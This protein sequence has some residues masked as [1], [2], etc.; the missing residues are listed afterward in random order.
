M[1]AAAT[2]EYDQEVPGVVWRVYN[3]E[4]VPLTTDL[5][6]EGLAMQIAALFLRAFVTTEIRQEEKRDD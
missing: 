2:S 4:G 1:T 5:K 6:T 3:L